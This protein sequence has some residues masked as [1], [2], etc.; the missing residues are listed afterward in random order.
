MTV[1]DIIK[2]KPYLAW[3]VKDKK[4]LSNEAVLE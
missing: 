2:N 1:Q 4:F 3:H